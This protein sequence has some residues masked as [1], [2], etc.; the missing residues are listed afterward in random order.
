M[1][2]I[3][4]PRGRSIM[5]LQN[6]FTDIATVPDVEELTGYCSSLQVVPFIPTFV[7]CVLDMDYYAACW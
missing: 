5:Y 7:A 2:P 4:W 6:A 1:H 3:P